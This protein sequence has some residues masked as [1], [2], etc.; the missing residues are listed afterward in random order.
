MGSIL[1]N[2]FEIQILDWKAPPARPYRE[3]A[4]YFI[5]IFGRLL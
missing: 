4:D 5:A 3:P 2:G 1:N